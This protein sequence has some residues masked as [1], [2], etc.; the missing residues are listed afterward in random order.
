MQKKDLYVLK[1]EKKYKT[2][3]F[4]IYISIKVMAATMFNTTARNRYLV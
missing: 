1:M 2:D 3:S 4:S